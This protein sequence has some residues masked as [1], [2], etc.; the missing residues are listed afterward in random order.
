MG[1]NPLI[2]IYND[3][4]GKLKSSERRLFF[5]FTFVVVASF[6]FA[7]FLKPALNDINK[8]NK[9]LQENQNQLGMLESQLPSAAKA[10]QEIEAIKQNLKD[11][12]LKISD[13]ESKLISTEQEQQ[14]LTEVI[15][16]A[17]G[18]GVD[19]ESVKEDIKE[20]KEGFARLYI[21][22]KFASNYKKAVTYIKR[23][24]SI[25]PFVKIEEMSLAQS[26]NE[27]LSTVDI[28]LRLSA[29]LSYTSK[30][31]SQLSS[32]AKEGSADS[33]DFKRSP[34]TPKFITEKNK[35]KKLKVTGI[36][37][38]NNEASSTAIINGA[39]VKIGDQAEG[40]KIERISPNS[41]VVDNGVEKETLKL[42]R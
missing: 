23:M 30:N 5:I 40:V 32:S 27:P 25:S 34:F 4:Y 39:I 11:L 12:K 41:V 13:I 7:L 42:E 22:L 31:Q 21:D 35:G 17:Q 26:K 29:L 1:V 28:S 37:Y 15:K 9:Q 3:W 33:G 2:G 20:E 16:N 36:T 38:R 6:Y 14:L 8:L 19:L 24:E 10:K 18:L